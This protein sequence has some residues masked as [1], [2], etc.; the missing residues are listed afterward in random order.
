[1]TVA[2]RGRIL[3]SP[4]LPGAAMENIVYR[5]E[6]LLHYAASGSVTAAPARR[7][8][9]PFADMLSRSRKVT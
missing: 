1:M 6:K 7:R 3:R 8:P 9:R 5:I 2:G 4:D